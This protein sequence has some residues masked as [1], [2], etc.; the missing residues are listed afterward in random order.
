MITHVRKVCTTY[1]V[2]GNGA[3]TCGCEGPERHDHSGELK[4]AP[5]GTRDRHNTQDK[6]NSY[7][8]LH[9]IVTCLSKP[10]KP[11]KYKYRRREGGSLLPPNYVRLREAT[12]RRTRTDCS[13]ARTPAKKRSLMGQARGTPYL[14]CPR[15]HCRGRR[16]SRH[17]R[18]ELSMPRCCG[19]VRLPYLKEQIF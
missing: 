10:L 11:P 7:F 6:L 14:R 13:L 2:H 1:F 16:R 17:P 4:V 9:R 5:I 18:R 8:R 3:S 12:E 15:W 19:L